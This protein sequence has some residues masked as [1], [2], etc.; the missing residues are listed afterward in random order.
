LR[1]LSITS[2]NVSSRLASVDRNSGVPIGCKIVRI[3]VPEPGWRSSVKLVPSPWT[4]AAITMS[5]NTGTLWNVTESG[6]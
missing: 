3:S 6:A 4:S 2:C 5:S 1:L